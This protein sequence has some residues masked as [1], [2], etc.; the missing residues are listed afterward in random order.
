MESKMHSVEMSEAKKM[1]DCIRDHKNPGTSKV[2][3]AVCDRWLRED[4]DGGLHMS[5]AVRALLETA[6]LPDE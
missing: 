6:Q 1:I 3:L 2:A 4:D 5:Q